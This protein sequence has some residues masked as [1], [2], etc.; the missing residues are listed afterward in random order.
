[1]HLVAD[2]TA[3][4]KMEIAFV[5]NPKGTQIQPLLDRALN[6]YGFQIND[7]RYERVGSVLVAMRK[8]FGTSEMQILGCMASDAGLANRAT[9]PEAAVYCAAKF[10]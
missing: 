10:K 5:G 7:D 9:L 4:Q 2:C 1:M 8:Q 6:L 3:L